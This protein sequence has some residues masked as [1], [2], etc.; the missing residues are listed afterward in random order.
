MDANEIAP[1]RTGRPSRNRKHPFTAA[2]AK[3]GVTM[4][5][6]AAS[7]RRSR[8]GLSSFCYPADHPQ[9]R[10]VPRALAEHWRKK[11]GVPMSAWPRIAD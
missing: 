5:E 3:A 1:A 8:M 6:E 7:V 2:L 9:F 10:P 4:T 11:Y